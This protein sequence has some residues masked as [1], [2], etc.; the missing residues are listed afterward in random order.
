MSVERIGNNYLVCIDNENHVENEFVRRVRKRISIYASLLNGKREKVNIPRKKPASEMQQERTIKAQ[1][2]RARLAKS[3]ENQ[4]FIGRCWDGIK[5]FFGKDTGSEHVENQIN[6]YERGQISEEE[7]E[8]IFNEYKI[9]QEEVVDVTSDIVSGI[10]AVGIYAAAL[11][12]APFSGGVSIA[13]GAA[14]AT[15]T[16]A[17]IKTGIKYSDSAAKG[18]EYGSGWYDLATGAFSGILAPITGGMGGAVGKSVA[19][20]LG[21]QA[22]SET[23]KAMAS[24]TLKASAYN[25]LFNPTGYKYLGGSMFKRAIAFG[26]ECAADGAVGGSVD[27]MF[28]AALNGEDITEAGVNGFL[29]GLVLSPVIGGGL[30][31]T[32]KVVKKVT[33]GVLNIKTPEIKVNELEVGLRKLNYRASYIKIITASAT[34]ENLPVLMGLVHIAAKKGGI[35]SDIDKLAK[36]ATKEDLSYIEELA[37]LKNKDDIRLFNFGK[38]AEILSIITPENEI[39]VKKLIANSSNTEYALNILGN[40]KKI[41]EVVDSNNKPIIER[42]ID[43]KTKEGEPRFA[44]SDVEK[45]AKVVTDKNMPIVLELANMQDKNGK[46]IFS[47]FEIFHLVERTTIE[48]LPIVNKLATLK[49][50]SGA[51]R[52]LG[53]HINDLLEKTTPENLELAIEIAKLTK[54]NGKSLFDTNEICELLEVTTSENI[55]FIK[56]LANITTKKG[57]NRFYHFDIIN[58]IERVNKDNISLVKELSELTLPNGKFRFSGSDLYQVLEIATEENMPYIKRYVECI[59]LDGNAAF[60]SYDIVEL[61]KFTTKE[62]ENI[63]KKL[64]NIKDG[65]RTILKCNNIIR[66]VQKDL[67]KNITLISKLAHLKTKDGKQLFDGYSIESILKEKLDDKLPLFKKLGDLVTEEGPIRLNKDERFAIAKIITNENYSIIEK[68]LTLRGK[69][70]VSP[71]FSVWEIRSYW[72][73]IAEKDLPFLERLAEITNKDGKEMFSLETITKILSGSSDKSI[74]SIETIKNFC[75]VLDN[76]NDVINAIIFHNIKDIKNINEIPIA[77]K[78]DFLRSLISA[79]IELFSVGEGF[80]KMF[81]I[82]PT[83]KEEY[84]RLLPALVRSL[85]VDTEPLSAQTVKTFNTN[86]ETLSSVLKKISDEDFSTLNITQTY[87]KND[88]ITKTLKV[89]K[90]LETKERQKVYD[91]FGFEITEDGSIIGYP[92]NLNNGK[93]LAQITDEKTKMVV[94]QLRPEVIKFTENNPVR[95]NNK[96]VE[97]LLNEIVSVLPEL[98]AQIGKVQH[99]THSYDV[100]THSLKVMQK[101]SQDPN[102]EKL[103]DSDK[104]LMMLA[105]LLHDITKA[106]GLSDKTHAKEGAFDAFFIAK[107]FGLTKEEEI[108][109]HTL[110]AHHEWLERANTAKTQAELTKRLQDIA[111]DLRNDNLFEMALMFTHA[112]LK[113][114]KNN[115]SFHDTNV[116]AARTTIDGTQRSFGESAEVYAA[117]IRKNIAEL[118]KSQPILPTTKIPEASR[119]NSAITHVNPDGSTNIKGVYKDKDGLVI[120]KFN[121][122][123]DWEVIGFPAGSISRGVQT[124]LFDGTEVDTGNI[125][126]IVHGLDY[127][128]QLAKFDA[129]S[130]VDSD[131]LLSVSYTERPETKFRFFR[132][133]GVI[134]DVDTKYIHGGGNTDS[135]SGCGKNI[136]EF[137]NNY[138]FGGERE[139]DRLYI[140]NLIKEA[141]GMDDEAYIAFQKQYENKSFAE[142]QPQELREKIIKIFAEINSNTRKGNRAYNEMYISN[143]NKVSG[144]FVYPIENQKEVGNAVEFLHSEYPTDNVNNRTSFLRK[145]AIERNIPLILFCDN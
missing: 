69:D 108:K 35:D 29:G 128:N 144:V 19:T 112:D 134:L 81:P 6:A 61:V 106:E 129:F 58:F 20:K 23:G 83:S 17:A 87:S 22:I 45:L 98:R 51:Q 113:S 141:T 97:A 59:G 40:I 142:I 36:I 114:V 68:L 133:Q 85:G 80:K 139:S 86:I 73:Q 10:A 71:R 75:A 44:S 99:K 130:L 120:I 117:Q 121:E 27:N 54:Q 107:K 78:K 14:A 104:K 110:V 137:K 82:I 52:F 37:G 32:G 25:M 34:E 92:V 26:A 126:F 48:N 105:A 93:K 111:Y 12:A 95:C 84:C 60:P 138:I 109:L 28:R 90:D 62:N 124:R 94:E 136:D 127:E 55:S 4:A 65:N 76:E 89:T 50:K 2:L 118:K 43:I 1:K 96:N 16:G 122:V 7:I 125:K 143:P 31:G 103:N 53:Y 116:G 88:F 38:I 74:P 42:L 145:Y 46:Y 33:N 39:L 9:G 119:I 11:A 70:N 132:T 102:F 30:K 8:K 5:N 49:T 72:S 67:C 63:I 123:E 140:S 21:V 135:G 41:I 47:G 100:F 15:A 115:D 57:E 91:Y 24:N 3:K 66:L 18:N 77:M 79:N 101:L 131:A 64:I 13:L 56:E